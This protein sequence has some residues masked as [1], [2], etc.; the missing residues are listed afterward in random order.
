MAD[1]LV[2]SESN[3]N[4]RWFLRMSIMLFLL[5]KYFPEYTTGPDINNATKYILWRD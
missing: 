1:S 5:Q 3:I 4:S 2:L